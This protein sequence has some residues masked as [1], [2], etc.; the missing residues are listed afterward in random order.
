MAWDE[1]SFGEYVRRCWDSF[2]MD[3]LHEA[4]RQSVL[5]SCAIADQIAQ[6]ERVR[7][8]DV[9]L[10]EWGNYTSE[11]AFEDKFTS[12][13]PYPRCYLTEHTV[14]GQT[15]YQLSYDGMLPLYFETNFNT[16][17]ALRNFERERL[18]ELSRYHNAVR[19]Y[20]LRATSDTVKLWPKEIKTFSRA[21]IYVCH[22][23]GNLVI[24]DLDN[25]NRS[26]LINAARLCGFISG[27]EWERLEFME[28]GYLDFDKKN[29]VSVF[30]SSQEIGL[31]MVE[32]VKNLYRNG[33]R[34]RVEKVPING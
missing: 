16:K 8:R 9:K 27:D 24:R 28:S 18:Q 20:Y 33:H 34:F 29:H 22:F 26:I 14:E 32:Y 15:V 30:I 7:I 17:T 1:E 13:T 31:K 4:Y 5:V 11:T 25:R 12:E 21:F 23:F 6:R 2:E 3:R 19:D 10:D